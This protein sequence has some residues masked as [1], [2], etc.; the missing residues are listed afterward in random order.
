MSSP[1]FKFNSTTIACQS[2]VHIIL[3]V[4]QKVNV[5]FSTD[6]NNSANYRK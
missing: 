3:Q 6:D 5:A 2:I 4:N 1:L